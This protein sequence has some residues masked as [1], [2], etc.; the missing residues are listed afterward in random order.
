MI[1]I[2]DFNNGIYGDHILLE[3]L[4]AIERPTGQ[5]KYGSFEEYALD[6]RD[7]EHL[8]EILEIVDREKENIYSAIVSFD[9]P[10]IFL[11][12]DA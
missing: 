3:K 12:C 9:P 6:V 8:K 4:G 7:F 2:I 5:T 10:T 11:D 1:F